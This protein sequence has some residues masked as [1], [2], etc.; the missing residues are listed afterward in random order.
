MSGK[1]VL[2]TGSNRGIGLAFATHYAKQ[3]WNVIAGVRDLASA[4]DLKGFRL[5]QVDASDEISILNAAKALEGV[6]ID[7]L[8]NNAGIGETHGLADTT[9]AGLLQQFEVNAI[10]PFLMTR[11]FLPNMKLAVAVCGSAIVGQISS[12]M[13]SISDN[14]S[15][16]LY[17]YRASK[18]AVNMINSSLAV[19]LKNDKIIAVALHPGYVVTRM[20]GFTG[21]LSPEAS[22]AGLTKVIEGL[23]P[24]DSGK[25]YSFEGKI[26][27]W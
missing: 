11:A 3:G 21:G 23:T 14:G 13:G 22:V 7:L 1:T 17:G 6:P 5:V 18:A 2:I 8:L 4:T 20:T 16:R 12:R 19:D 24:E 26:V 15:G 25:F 27:P 10:G 9:K